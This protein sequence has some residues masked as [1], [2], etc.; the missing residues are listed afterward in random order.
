M[1]SN[2]ELGWGT[3]R[4]SKIGPHHTVWEFNLKPDQEYF[5]NQLRFVIISVQ[6]INSVSFKPSRPFVIFS[7]G[8]L[9]TMI[10]TVY[11]PKSSVGNSHFFFFI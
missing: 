11:G 4:G 10:R 5:A 9:S 7:S 2:V 1:F 3:R 8:F 6:L